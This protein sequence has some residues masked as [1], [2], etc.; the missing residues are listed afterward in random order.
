MQNDLEDL[1]IDVKSLQQ[2]VCLLL[3]LMIALHSKNCPVNIC[4][5]E[6]KKVEQILGEWKEDVSRG[7]DT[8]WEDAADRP[9]YDRIGEKVMFRLDDVWHKAE[10]VWGYR[11][12]DGIKNVLLEDGRTAGCGTMRHGEFVRRIEVGQ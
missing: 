1:K 9:Y 5:E 3:D 6:L 4:G 10:V 12:H 11:T 8:Y 7:K 2:K